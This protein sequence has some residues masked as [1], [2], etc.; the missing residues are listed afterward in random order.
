M[1]LQ[2]L[3]LFN[4]GPYKDEQPLLFPIDGTRHVMTVFGDNMRGKTSLMNALRWVFYAKAINR[5]GNPINR[6][7]LLNYEAAQDGDYRMWVSL[8]FH[9]DGSDF[10]LRREM[11]SLPMVYQ[12]RSD[13]D[14]EMR[15]LLKRDGQVVLGDQVE[16]Y[17][18][19]CLPQQI[20]RFYLFDAELLQEYEMLVMEESDQ[21][22]KIRDAIE[23]ILGVPTLVNARD[24]LQ[25]LL[26]K[27]Q[28]AQAQEMEANQ[29][30]QEQANQ[31]LKLQDEVTRLES[32]LSKSKEKIQQIRDSI[33][34]MDDELSSWKEIQQTVTVIDELKRK[35]SELEKQEQELNRQQLAI[36]KS[37][38]MDL[39]QPRLQIRRDAITQQIQHSKERLMKMGVL[40]SEIDKHA[41]ILDQE[42]CPLCEQTVPE[43]H[44]RDITRRLKELREENESL[45]NER[46]DIGILTDELQKINE[47]IPMGSAEKLREVRRRIGQ[48]VIAVTQTENE[49]DTNLEK[50]RGHKISQISETQTKRDA[51][52]KAQ[53]QAEHALQ[54]AQKKIEER[55]DKIKQLAALLG[56]QTG[57]KTIAS[58]Q[59]EIY[60]KL[61]DV[62]SKAIEVMRDSLRETIQY[63]ATQV[64]KELTTEKTYSGLQINPNYG[65][66]ILDEFGQPVPMRSAGAEQ[67]VAMSLLS[68]LNK[69]S[70]RSGPV[71]IDTPFGRLDPKH[72]ENILRYLPK[73]ADQVIL[74]V[75]AGELNPDT[76]LQGIADQVG[77]RYEIQRVTSSHSQLKKVVN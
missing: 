60:T 76:G 63:E 74:L 54:E 14:F 30:Y 1:I 62:Y 70:A 6:L 7:S 53:G 32:D 15:V 21:E 31:S 20:S 56:N 35:K 47:I 46:T 50:I 5:Y 72:R 77:A 3:T 38:W 65:L 49:L 41:Q 42:R 26:K 34:A 17:V 25:T 8:A 40:A 10:E 43:D 19:Q 67:V 69:A 11:Q 28:K 66:T 73:M 64:F 61:L 29:N 12:P 44:K 27:A 2:R 24:D 39:L 48:T 58:R 51:Y 59:V 55:T 45:T 52:V 23:Q 4:F 75:H 36:I 18:E 9:H 16:W 71:V 57:S 13:K 37:A 22:R 33:R 68:A